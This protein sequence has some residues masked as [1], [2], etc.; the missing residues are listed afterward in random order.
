MQKQICTNPC[1]LPT[2]PLGVLENP[3]TGV[4]VIT[5]HIVKLSCP[6]TWETLIFRLCAPKQFLGPHWGEYKDT[7][8]T[9]WVKSIAA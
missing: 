9:E 5:N 3:L 4:T 6:R 2:N 7:E 8:A 1:G